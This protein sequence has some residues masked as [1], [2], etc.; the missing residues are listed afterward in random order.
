MSLVLMRR[1]MK[2]LQYGVWA[3]IVIFVLG[4]VFSFNASSGRGPGGESGVFARIGKEEVST[5]QFARNL[6]M[7]REQY[8]SFA[9]YGQAASL[10]QY[11]ELPRYAWEQLLEEYAQAA[12]AEKRGVT[13]SISEADKELRNQVEERL[14][15]VGVGATPAELEQYRQMLMAGRDVEGQRRQM[16]AQR[17]RDK[18]SQEVSPVEVKVA[19]VLIKT[20]TRT[21][22]AARKLAQD[23]AKQAKAGADFAKLASQHSEDTGSKV[24]GGEVGWASAQPPSPPTGENA[25][26]DPEAATSFVPEFTAAALM[27]KP[28]QVSDPVKSTFGYHVLKALAVR[29]FKPKLDDVAAKPAAKPGEK[30]DVAAAD[31]KRQEAIDQ[32][33]TA[34]A[35]QIAQGLFSEQKA[36]LESQVKPEAAWLKGYLLEQDAN[37]APMTLD[38]A[39]KP[40][41]T[42]AQKL[43][44][45]IA[46]YEEALKGGGAEVGP[47]LAYKLAQLYQRAE[48]YADASTL[49][50][51]WSK[52][53]GNAEMY[54]LHAEVL[55]KLK[56]KTEAIAAYQS[57]VEATYKNPDLL[58]RVADKFKELGRTDLAQSTRAKSAKQ[59][60]QQ[61][62]ERALQ[63]KQQ[64]QAMKEATAKAAAEAAAKPK[65]APAADSQEITVKTGPIDP[66][67]GKPTILSVTPGGKD[68]KAGKPDAKEAAPAKP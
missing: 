61:A 8:R 11:A 4:A 37:K 54:V 1:Q 55:E 43:A 51:K 9:S 21:D 68:A 65:P 10:Q 19:H 36:L 5:E 46:A 50:E 39:G 64:E 17:L 12:A 57:A 49:L 41:V 42:E 31:K 13:V 44:P 30:P 35:N 24:K 25:K 27:L 67:T 56:K 66:K 33:K 15:T 29:D 63:Q 58:N 45:A 60:A 3:F 28:G 6:S 38:K 53:S 48:R 22:E 52:K 14:K 2:Y 40:A 59:V 62:E 16:L 26:P 47:P 32:Y 23:I 34:M 18:L 20:E 7:M